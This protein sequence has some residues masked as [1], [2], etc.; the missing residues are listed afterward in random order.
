[1][2]KITMLFLGML[3]MVF[4]LAA[5]HTTEYTVTFQSNGGTVVELEKVEKGNLVPQPAVDRDGY[6]LNG[7]FLE[8]NFQTE[9]NFLLDTVQNDI[10]LYAKWMGSTNIE[11]PSI[12]NLTGAA[13]GGSISDFPETTTNLG[14]STTIDRRNTT[15]LLSSRT[16]LNTTLYEGYAKL[17]TKTL[18]LQTDPLFIYFNWDGSFN[19]LEDYTFTVDTSRDLEGQQRQYFNLRDYYDIEDFEVYVNYIRFRVN[20]VDELDN[21]VEYTFYEGD[22]VVE[23]SA[24]S[25]F[26]L[27]NQSI[28]FNDNDTPE[29]TSDD[30]YDIAIGRSNIDA[31]LANYLLA[32]PNATLEI[33]GVQLFIA[34]RDKMLNYWD[35]TET[36]E[37]SILRDGQPSIYAYF[38]A[39][40]V[41][42]E[43]LGTIIGSNKTLV[44][45]YPSL[46]SE[47][48]TVPQKTFSQYHG[49]EVTDFED[50]LGLIKVF[51]SLEN[52]EI[53][54]DTIYLT[55]AK[56][57]FAGGSKEPYIG[58]RQDENPLAL[59]NTIYYSIPVQANTTAVYEDNE[60]NTTENEYL[61]AQPFEF[62]IF[63]TLKDS[64]PISSWEVIGL[65]QEHPGYYNIDE[66]GNLTGE[67]QPAVST[68]ITS[69]LFDNQ[70]STDLLAVYSVRYNEDI[71]D[72]LT[73]EVLY[74]PN[75]TDKVLANITNTMNWMYQGNIPIT[76][77]DGLTMN[78]VI[79]TEVS[80]YAYMNYNF[81][82]DAAPEVY[83]A[84]QRLDSFTVSERRDQ[85]DE[86]MEFF[87]TYDME[88]TAEVPINMF[89]HTV[90]ISNQIS[91]FDNNIIITENNSKTI[92]GRIHNEQL[93]DGTVDYFRTQILFDYS[94][95]GNYMNTILEL[96]LPQFIT[97]MRSS[98]NYQY[99][100]AL[101]ITPKE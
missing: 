36:P 73:G 63:I 83:D 13:L 86:F 22:A 99:L 51:Y 1:M 50:Y 76:L 65:D 58:L 6:S 98:I 44:T 53:A 28:Q 70:N 54:G 85:I 11:D 75:S 23:S 79:I 69:H 89:P 26:I 32:D 80:N 19:W 2:K 4:S 100:A 21:P 101:G 25:S 8:E 31:T 34:Y 35:E 91:Y 27:N 41:Y 60:F 15:L 81:D 14:S 55:Q 30:N 97:S 68:P 9:W 17:E 64:N 29:D 3:L 46:S 90:R 39:E 42:D 45:Y 33:I 48:S 56:I 7:W 84:Y 59:D 71:I 16:S 93:N 20:T 67:Y 92:Y 96:S 74:Y 12:I 72:L 82:L 78:D 37:N 62:L 49:S 77:P 47:E 43:E 57:E 66:F 94:V 5:C 88:Q 95:L 61:M 24:G 87:Y 18:D 38:D 10:T 40:R 52:E